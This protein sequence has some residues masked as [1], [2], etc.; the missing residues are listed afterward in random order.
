[1][2]ASSSSAPPVSISR[3]DLFDDEI[4]TEQSDMNQ[5]WAYGLHIHSEL[6]L[7]ELVPVPGFHGEVTIKLGRV[8]HDRSPACSDVCC[9]HL[10]NRE[11]VFF[12]QGIA[13]FLVKN[14]SEVVIDPAPEADE[15]YLR[16]PLLGILLAVLLHQRGLLVLHGSAVAIRDEVNVFIGAK[17][18]GKSTT[19]AMLYG[20]GHKLMADD[21]VAVQFDESGE[22]VV[23]PGY[24]QLKLWPEAAA[25]VLGA[26]SESLPQ[27]VTGYDKRAHRVAD[28]LV[29]RPV[30]LGRICTLTKGSSLRLHRLVPQEA[31]TDLI[32]H[33][34][35]ARFGRQLLN[36]E[37]ARA[38]LNQCSELV[39]K[40]PVYRLERPPSLAVLEA[41]ARLLE[42]SPARKAESLAFERRA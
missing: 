26:A 29:R 2:V 7:P 18:S 22:A 10:S 17:G 21:L 42:R 30:R 28:D 6:V 16:L 23:V 24:P 38:H 1:M 11:A 40:V 13:S 3:I 31:L 4:K 39:G 36:G 9:F 27:L 25:R 35:V 33:T 41:T 14:G 20:R 32:A 37:A 19:A 8:V 12:W 34:Y 15:R 5:Y